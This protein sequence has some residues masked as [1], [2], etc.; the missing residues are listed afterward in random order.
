[1]WTGSLSPSILLPI[2]IL[3]HT[4]LYKT[5][6]TIHNYTQSKHGKSKPLKQNKTVTFQD[7]CILEFCGGIRLDKHKIMLV[8][9]LTLIKETDIMSNTLCQTQL[10]HII[11]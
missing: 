6:F 4:A 7:S 2:D 8:M 5:K 9:S 10:I 1:M 11:N 3:R